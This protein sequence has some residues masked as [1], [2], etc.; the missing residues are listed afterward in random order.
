MPVDHAQDFP[1]IKHVVSKLYPL[2]DVFW[3][4]PSVSPELPIALDG[5]AQF[6]SSMQPAEL[7]SFWNKVKEAGR[8][9]LLDANVTGLSVGCNG[10][11]QR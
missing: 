5:D 4:D 7:G 10:Q 6:M 1:R 11:K 8:S 2:H 3:T 9:L